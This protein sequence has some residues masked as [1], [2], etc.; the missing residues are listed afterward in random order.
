VASLACLVRL[1][2]WNDDRVLQLVGA[3]STLTAAGTLLSRSHSTT[4]PTS[5]V[6][7][8]SEL[9][10][11][12]AEAAREAWEEALHLEQEGFVLDPI[13]WPLAAVLLLG[14]VPLGVRDLGAAA[15]A[16]R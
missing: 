12:E 8:L 1:P 5:T 9:L 2:G 6:A 14:L 4:M 13:H 11:I 7:D 16:R 3:F 15:P 10:A